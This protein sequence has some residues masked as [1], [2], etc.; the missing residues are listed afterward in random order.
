M[1]FRISPD[2]LNP[3]TWITIRRPAVNAAAIRDPELRWVLM[4]VDV[5]HPPSG[6]RPGLPLKVTAV[7][8]PF[9]YV[10]AM[11]LSGRSPVV[12]IVDLDEHIVVGCDLE[13]GKRIE[14][15]VHKARCQ[16][17]V[18]MREI[19]RR[20]PA[21]ACLGHTGADDLPVDPDRADDSDFLDDLAA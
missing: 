3:G 20:R 17:E 11:E 5:L 4:L 9:V 21:D 15:E 14:D 16:R 7:D 6:P 2:D 18:F 19:K 12:E 8:L 10:R 13:I 1:T